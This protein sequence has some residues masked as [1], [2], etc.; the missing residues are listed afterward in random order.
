MNCVLKRRIFTYIF[1][2]FL[3]GLTSQVQAAAPPQAAVAAQVQSVT[4][5]V[6]NKQ[7]DEKDGKLTVALGGLSIA[8]APSK[9]TSKDKGKQPMTTFDKIVVQ[10]RY[11]PCIDQLGFD[12]L[13]V[14]RDATLPDPD[15]SAKAARC[16]LENRA[17][18]LFDIKDVIRQVNQIYK[19]QNLDVIIWL[20]N[21]YGSVA[22]KTLQWYADNVF[23]NLTS[24]S[25]VWGA[26]L[27][28]W[29]FIANNS[30]NL[31]AAKPTQISALR[32]INPAKKDTWIS[33]TEC[34]FIQRPLGM[35]ADVQ[36]ARFRVLQ[37]TDFFQW[38][39]SLK[40]SVNDLY[41]DVCSKLCRMRP[42]TVSS[43]LDAPDA[44]LGC[45][46]RQIGYYVP[47][48]D[49]QLE[50]FGNKSF[51]DIDI[52]C[53]FPVLQYLETI[54]YIYKIAAYNAACNEASTS[55]IIF[56]VNLREITFYTVPG[57]AT[58]FE[59]L[60]VNTWQLLSQLLP[61][62]AQTV[63]I[64]IQPFAYLQLHDVP[65][66]ASGAIFKKLSVFSKEIQACLPK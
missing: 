9:D 43:N 17:A 32:A 49:V 41:G 20:T 27:D 14:L 42:S 63:V 34:P 1:S 8:P 53:T 45:T 33:A 47:Y 21:Y 35:L 12:E 15:G 31:K 19:G 13:K 10:V 2:L 16:A 65:C 3:C 39:V 7:S 25:M 50:R 64:D 48:L 61:K 55:N 28:K 37:S 38:L 52:Y 18:K 26:N 51:L 4:R 40:G 24:T 44:R 23:K 66:K 58:P 36:Q 22:K 59:T 5:L 54:Y 29:M 46:F 56:L 57:E 30:A 11:N 60:G 62:L 6:N